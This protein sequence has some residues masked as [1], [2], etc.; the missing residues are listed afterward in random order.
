[1]TGPFEA[2]GIELKGYRVTKKKLK[3]WTDNRIPHTVL[4]FANG[5]VFNSK[6]DGI[7]EST[8]FK[9]DTLGGFWKFARDYKRA[10]MWTQK[11]I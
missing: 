8:H 11:N 9:Y 7:Y 10:V 2:L 6:G 5:G 1:M 3:E 4:L